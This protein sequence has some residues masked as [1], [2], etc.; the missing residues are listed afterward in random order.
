MDQAVNNS[1][2]IVKIRNEGI[3]KTTVLNFVLAPKRV[4]NKIGELHPT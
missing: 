1:T 4:R 3:K 2:F